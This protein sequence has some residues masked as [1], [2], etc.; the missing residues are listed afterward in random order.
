MTMI[1]VWHIRKAPKDAVYIG[2]ECNGYF[3][4]PFCKPLELEPKGLYSDRNRK[5]EDAIIN[6]AIYWF[7]PEQKELRQKAVEV[8]PDNVM[9]WCA[10]LWCHGDIVA[11][12]VNWKRGQ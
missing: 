2:R 6:F 1:K 8:L 12:Y 4:S 7:A 10:P 9:C 11:G 3:R 5:R